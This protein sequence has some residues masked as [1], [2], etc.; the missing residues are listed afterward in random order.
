M[1]QWG[2]VAPNGRSNVNPKVSNPKVQTNSKIKLLM[3]L[4]SVAGGIDDSP[5][6][7]KDREVV[8]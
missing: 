6:F 2:V 7:A 8:C 5:G 1:V 3:S 4:T